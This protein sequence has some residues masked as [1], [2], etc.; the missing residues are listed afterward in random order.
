MNRDTIPLYY[1]APAL[2]STNFSNQRTGWI[3]I[4]LRNLEHNVETIKEKMQPQSELM[5]VVKAK[6]YGHGEYEISTCLNK[7]GVKAFAVATID[8]GI[9]LR[10]YGI[11]GE[12]LVLGYTAPERAWEVK[13]YHLIQ[14]VL[15]YDY[16]KSLN[17]QGVRIKVHIKVDTGMHR[18]GIPHDRWL[19]AEEIFQMKYLNVCGIYTHLCCADSL[20]TEDVAYTK[21][22]IGKFY[23]LLHALEK[24][25][26]TIPKIHIQSSY[27]LWNYPGLQCD[28]VRTGISL[29]GVS[30]VSGRETRQKPDL[31]PVLALKAR[32]ILIRF[33]PKDES[34]GYGRCHITDRDSKIAILPIGYADGIPRALSCKKSRVL[35]RGKE[36]PIIGMVCMDQLAVD[37]TQIAQAAV[38]DIATFISP[39]RDSGL[40]APAVAGYADSISNEL[41]CRLGPRLPVIPQLSGNADNLCTSSSFR[42]M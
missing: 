17:K 7:M 33:V 34:I 23:A 42:P 22:Q 6:A 29:Y 20:L 19:E 2:I 14:T 31:L 28:Y 41:L 36:A 5:A 16:A 11:K 21:E 13:K 39:E 18:L 15:D 40:Y 3:E 24:S 26:I 30:S 10:K 32:V 35:I 12:I 8:E 25:G 4:N 27:G 38:G 37:I 9:R 1:H